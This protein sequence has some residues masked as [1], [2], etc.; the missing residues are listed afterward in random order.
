MKCYYHPTTD[1]VALCKSCSRALCPDCCA[2][3]PPGT[4]CKGKCEEDVAA[5]NM[6]IQRG[7]TAYQKTGK[8]YKRNSVVTLLLG[9]IFF[10]FG[11]VPIITGDGYGS[12][13]IAVLG[14]VFILG[15]YFSYQSGK[16]IQEIE[17][18]PNQTVEPTR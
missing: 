18:K 2:D 12:A 11:I 10:A 13:F 3:V 4:A 15:S 6:V 16:Q 8:A 9:L 14:A 5:L 7:K 17:R 1:A